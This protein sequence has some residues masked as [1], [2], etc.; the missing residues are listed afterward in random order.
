MYLLGVGLGLILVYLFFGSR[1]LPAW[2]P[3]GRV[4]TA[5][6]SSRQFY[7]ERALCQ[8][9]C[10]GLDSSLIPEMQADAKVKFSESNTKKKPCPVYLI[11]THFRKLDYQLIWEVCEDRERVKL[12]SLQSANRQCEC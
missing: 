12:L 5:I 6:D 4:M 2:T 3:E 1:D 11:N 9:E 7:S 8:L 10:H